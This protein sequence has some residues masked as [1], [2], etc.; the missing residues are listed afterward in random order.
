[1]LSRTR[2]AFDYALISK[3]FR[4]LV[5]GFAAVR[6]VP[7][8]PHVG[9]TLLLHASPRNI[10][11]R[12]L[13]KPKVPLIPKE[14]YA[15]KQERKGKEGE[16]QEAKDDEVDRYPGIGWHEAVAWETA[17]SRRPKPSQDIKGSTAFKATE[18]DARELGHFCA[19]WLETFEAF[20]GQRDLAADAVSKKDLREKLGEHFLPPTFLEGQPYRGT[21]QRISEIVLGAPSPPS[22]GG[23]AEEKLKTKDLRPYMG[24]GSGPK[25]IIEKAFQ[26]AQHQH[27]A[28][29]DAVAGWWAK[30]ANLL[31]HWRFVEKREAEEAGNK[32]RARRKPSQ[33]KPT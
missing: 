15:K 13:V 19:K 30:F 21:A 20:H 18:K 8:A 27:L 31:K 4:P 2:G 33:D 29:N 23:G 17:L 16:Q 28:H 22:A 6:K 32:D 26:G 14:A 7:W 1:M 9:L 24:R 25:F 11:T 3:S 10:L 12:S 5:K